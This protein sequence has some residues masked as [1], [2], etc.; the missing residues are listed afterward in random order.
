[1]KNRVQINNEN[2]KYKEDKDNEKK[3][4]KSSEDKADTEKRNEVSKESG[5]HKIHAFIIAAR[6]SDREEKIKMKWQKHKLRR[7]DHCREIVLK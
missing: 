2:E 1:M 5:E 4:R 7:I 3:I 6:E